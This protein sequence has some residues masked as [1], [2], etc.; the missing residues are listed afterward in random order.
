MRSLLKANTEDI[1]DREVLLIFSRDLDVSWH[2]LMS[3]PPPVE[4]CMQMSPLEFS[5]LFCCQ[6]VAK[7]NAAAYCQVSLLFFALWSSKEDCYLC[8]LCMSNAMWQILG[9]SML[10]SRHQV[11]RLQ[12]D[13]NKGVHNAKPWAA[14]HGIH[15]HVSLPQERSRLGRHQPSQ[16]AMEKASVGNPR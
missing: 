12:P 15:F 6:S 13:S 5:S 2:L 8:Q 3:L 4:I 16:P 9:S 11:T 10:L 14:G 1:T 7:I